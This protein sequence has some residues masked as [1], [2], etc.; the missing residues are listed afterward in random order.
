MPWKVEKDGDKFC[1]KKDT[2]ETVKCHDSRAK[3]VKHMRA[4]YANVKD[5]NELPDIPENTKVGMLVS[6]RSFSEGDT[7]TKEIMAVPY[8]AWD[9]PV[10]G[11]TVFDRAMAETM[12][13]NFDQRVRGQDIA[14]DYDHGQDPAKGGKASGWVKD[15]RVGDDALYWTVEFTEE[16]RKEINSGE[17]R[18]FSPE[19]FDSWTNPMAGGGTYSYVAVGGALTNKPW[20][21]GMVPLNFS[22]VMVEKEG[23]VVKYHKFEKDGTEQYMVVEADGTT[24]PATD[25]EVK[26]ESVEWEHSE[27]GSGSPPEPREEPEENDRSGRRGAGDGIRVDSPPEDTKEGSEVKFDKEFLE[28]IGIAPDASEDAIK[29]HIAA[30]FSELAPLR[31]ATKEVAKQKA[32]A[33]AYPEEAA[34]LARA[35][36]ERIENEARR[37]SERYERFKK[38]DDKTSTKGFSALVLSTIADTHKKFSEGVTP[39]ERTKAFGELMDLIANESAIVDYGEKGSNQDPEVEV[40]SGSKEIELA[41]SEKIREVVARDNIGWDEGIKKAS[42][43]NPDL[44]RRYH[45]VRYGSRA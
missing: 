42:A 9:H 16:A 36:T 41:F 27:P 23:D 39:D 20:I 3:A 34:E 37:F 15:M 11:M 29:E 21:K 22:E 8:D 44:A 1:V 30:A 25:L 5:F 19:W 26:D 28:S 12:K 18:Y 14:T 4:L 43:E 10:Y 35:R 38:D 2:G 31:E 6:V 32:F 33:E 7:V 17:W 40:P 24:R 45:E 13:I